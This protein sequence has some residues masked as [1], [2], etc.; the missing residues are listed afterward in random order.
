MQ[1]LF[2]CQNCHTQFEADDQNMVVCP[3]C[4]SDN[5]EYVSGRAAKQ[6]LKWGATTIVL[7][8]LIAVTIFV[9]K[10]CAGRQ[11]TDTDGDNDIPTD[12]AIAV[13]KDS[14]IIDINIPD[15]IK[16]PP[17][18]ETGSL[19]LTEDGYSFSFNVDHRPSQPF[20]VAVV[21]HRGTKEIIRSEDNKTF[22]KVPPSNAEEGK[23]DIVVIDSKTG[24][25]LAITVKPGF[26]PPVSQR[27][28][29]A[30]LQSLIDNDDESLY[31]IHK[32]IAENCKL[33]FTGL[34]SESKRPETLA[35]VMMKLSQ[36]WSAV[37]VTD[38]QYDSENRISAITMNVM[39]N[40]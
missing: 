36:M 34:P 33:S 28:T 10:S 24:E 15:E 31:G 7:L 12:T 18:I 9:Y 21:E 19:K 14:D 38:V 11:T 6:V 23:Y 25:I 37:Q 16:E 2:T 30:Q 26:T 3:H 39:L 5:V 35:D 20:F 40:E 27:L 13:V 4:Q 1:R 8:C 29:K 22:Q 32:Q 17:I